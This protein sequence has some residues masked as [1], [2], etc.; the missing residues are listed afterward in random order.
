MQ[1]R[2]IEPCVDVQVI[3]K[4]S[5]GTP[6]ATKLGFLHLP[7]ARNV[8]AFLLFGS[9]SDS[10]GCISCT[11]ERAHTVRDW[12]QSLTKKKNRFIGS[13]RLWNEWGYLK[14]QRNHCGNVDIVCGCFEPHVEQSWSKVVAEL[15][16]LLSPDV[17]S[18]R[19]WTVV[20]PSLPEFPVQSN[21]HA[22]FPRC[23]SYE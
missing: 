5:S 8:V 10:P 19:E 4:S 18:L 20:S 1:K 7:P 22:V 16:L 6:K 2:W 13:K 14:L 9:S 11:K 23:F 21:T 15:C 17:N 3:S 12:L